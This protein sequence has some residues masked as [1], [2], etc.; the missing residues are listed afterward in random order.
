M[1]A[2]STTTNSTNPRTVICRGSFDVSAGAGRLRADA[3]RA[4]EPE[5]GFPRGRGG[6]DGGD[7]RVPVAAFRLLPVAADRREPVLRDRAAPLPVRAD[8]PV[9]AARVRLRG[10]GGRRVVTCS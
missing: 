3:R 1:N 8:A 9:P 4:A 5:P 10:V 2:I 7:L 6:T